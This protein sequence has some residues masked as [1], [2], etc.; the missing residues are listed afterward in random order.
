M[1]RPSGVESVIGKGASDHVFSYSFIS[2]MVYSRRIFTIWMKKGF[3]L[4]LLVKASGSSLNDGMKE[5]A[6]G[7]VYRMA[8][9]SGLLLLRASAPTAL[10]CHLASYTKQCLA[11]YKIAGSKTSIP[12]T[13]SVSLPLLLLVGPMTSWGSRGFKISLTGRPR[14]ELEEDGCC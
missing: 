7:N 2:N 4:E 5:K 8:I 12:T 3:L 14:A 6:M 9:G 10:R 1:L 11:S 13:T